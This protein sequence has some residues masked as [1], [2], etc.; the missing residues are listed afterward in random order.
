MVSGKRG[1]EDARAP[2]ERVT[3]LKGQLSH[4]S[5]MLRSNRE[6]LNRIGSKLRRE[7]LVE[8]TSQMELAEAVLDGDLPEARNSR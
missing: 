3:M 7:D 4:H 6:E 2:P 8:R 5:Q 1:K